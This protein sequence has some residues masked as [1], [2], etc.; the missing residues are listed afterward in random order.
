MFA[1]AFLVAL[2]SL[3]L[4]TTSLAI[5]AQNNFR[6][7]KS[8]DSSAVCATGI[9]TVTVTAGAAAATGTNVAVSTGSTTGNN[10]GNKGGK[11]TGN[12]GNSGNNASGGKGAAGNN[13]KG[14][15]STSVVS[16]A[17]A[18]TTTAAAA[19]ATS[20]AATSSGNN[21]ASG[22]TGTGAT[23]NNLQ[24]SLTLDPSVVCSNFAATGNNPP[25]TGQVDS[26]TTTNNFINFCSSTNQKLPLTNGLQVTTGSCNPAPMG[27]IPSV[28]NL[29]ASKFQFPRNLD[30]VKSNT[31]FT[32]SYSIAHLQT[33][34]FTNAQNTYYAAPQQLNAAGDVIG[35]SHVVIEPQ[36]GVQSTDLVTDNK[37]AFFKG[38]NGAATNGILTVDVTQGLPAGTYK[39][40][41]I[42]SAAN[43]Q[44]V[45]MP[46]A[47]HRS[48]E[49]SVFFV[50]TD[51]GKAPAEFAKILGASGAA[52]AGT[53]T[54]AAGTGAA[55]ASSVA[56]SAAASTGNGKGSNN[57]AAG[58]AASSAVSAASSSAAAKA[59]SAASS[60]AAAAATSAATKGG[61][62]SGFKGGKP[63]K[64]RAAF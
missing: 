63:G 26:L 54:A 38:V 36:N 13:G 43:H 21:A 32:I 31:A 1:K 42:N 55:A 8:I 37:F 7:G 11:S 64:R 6:G 60:S 56:S 46:V 40:T 27:Q 48:T 10:T 45:L 28:N 33:G 15:T 17:V 61:K 25:V 51:D 12:S 23:G 29:V 14:T 39:L 4:A 57:A 24:T 16:S 58:T 2:L 5:P 49:D 35:H 50:V 41:T 62:S 3:S 9:T 30:I 22:K 18:A 20:S 34:S 59:T 52:A 53:G 47:Q 19:A 44:P